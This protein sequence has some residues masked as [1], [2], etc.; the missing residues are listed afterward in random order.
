MA[1][2]DTWLKA[3]HN[4]ART[5]EAEK[6]DRDGLSARVSPKGHIA[7]QLRFRIEGKAQRIRL[8]TY[9]GMS[10]K[11]ARETAVRFKAEL[12]KGHDP[13]V[14]KRTEKMQNLQALTVQDVFEHWYQ[15]QCVVHK[16]SAPEIYRSF[17]LHV[18]PVLGSI[19]ATKL[20]AND[21]MNLLDDIKLSSPAIADRILGNAKQMLSWAARREIV[22]RNVLETL[23]AK[24]DLGVTKQQRLRSLSDEELAQ[25]L[26]AVEHSRI[27][28][29][30]KMFLRLCLIY[31]CRNGELRTA[32]QSDLDFESKVWTVPADRHKTGKKVGR[33][34][35]RPIIPETEALFRLAI[36]LSHGSP[37]LFTNA[38]DSCMMGNKAPLSLPY[39]I[40][41][42]LR[43]QRHYE[44]EH[45]SIHD[46]R[47]TARTNFSK[48]TQPHIAEIMLGHKL[49][50]EWS[51]YDH[52]H[53][54]EEQAD[55]LRKWCA[56]L[57]ELG[58]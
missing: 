40:R 14:V 31:G 29:K 46:L 12:D 50:G 6:A 30:N 22:E 42:Y 25:V 9:P 34:L 52:H 48:L 8:G 16:K 21:W 49:P 13:R 37:Y 2:S 10:L 38:G 36:D 55:C 43:R 57:A 28:A 15:V 51:T 45:W 24:R 47:K 7:F 26:W 35:I 53:Y 54:L 44:M 19:P 33:P 39:H 3:N 17:K 11:E 4:K 27:T 5:V 58:S 41:Q 1:L 32:L 20:S 23:T 56:R 18:Y